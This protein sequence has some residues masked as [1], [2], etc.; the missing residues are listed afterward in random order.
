MIFFV[1]FSGCSQ[2]DNKQEDT[3]EKQLLL[4]LMEIR[5]NRTYPALF[6]N[7]T[8]GLKIKIGKIRQDRI[9]SAG[10]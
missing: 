7:N 1:I 3:P 9:D 5:R 8:R 6:Y 4:Q 2:E 10:Q